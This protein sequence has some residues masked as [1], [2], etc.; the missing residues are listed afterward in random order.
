MIALIGSLDPLTA[1]LAATLRAQGQA[2][3]ICTLGHRTVLDPLPGD[4]L[5]FRVEHLGTLIHHL[6]QSGIRAVC[7]SGGIHRPQVD[8]AQIDALTAPLVPLLLAALRQGDDGALRTVI[9]LFEQAGLAVLSA[10]D[11]VPELL[12]HPG[13][14]THHRPAPQHEA[15]AARAESVHRIIAPA[16]IGQGVIVRRGQVLAVEAQPGTDFMLR[17]V[18]GFAEGALFFKA[19]KLG[20]DRRADLPVIG[21]TTI[22]RARDAKLSAIVIEAGG[23]MVMNREATVAAANEASLVLWVREPG[24]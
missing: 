8:P 6:G 24:P 17:S 2:H 9:G 11:L 5:T 22:E 13:V 19:P 16:D 3:M 14:L 15:D 7:F 20:Q 4:P 23:V 21:P 1:L 12:P 18:K 10:Q